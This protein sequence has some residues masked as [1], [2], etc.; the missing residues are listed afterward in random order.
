MAE[1]SKK[2]KSSNLFSLFILSSSRSRSAL[3]VLPELL[4]KNSLFVGQ[5]YEEN[6]PRFGSC[7]DLLYKLT[8]KQ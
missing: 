1:S 7:F 3:L 5:L 8:Y 4:S 2:L 6:H